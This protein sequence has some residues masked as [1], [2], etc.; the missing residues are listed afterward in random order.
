MWKTPL[1]N[2]RWKRETLPEDVVEPHGRSRR[3]YCSVHRSPLQPH[4]S[5]TV[6]R[7]LTGLTL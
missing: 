5:A 7:R 2:R 1:K 3:S 4:H 6:D